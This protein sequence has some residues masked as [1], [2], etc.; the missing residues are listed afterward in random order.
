MRDVSRSGA[1]TDL[2]TGAVWVREWEQAMVL[3][4]LKVTRT[5]AK[6]LFGS[7]VLS[8]R[9]SAPRPVRELVFSVFSFVACDS[10]IVSHPAMQNQLSF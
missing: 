8:V 6:A 1:E 7:T 2:K 5:E 10:A 3:P 9:V 4:E